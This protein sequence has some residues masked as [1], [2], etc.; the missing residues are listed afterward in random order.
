MNTVMRV[1][2]ASHLPLINREETAK[3]VKM[4]WSCSCDWSQ[5]DGILQSLI[6]RIITQTKSDVF[7]EGKLQ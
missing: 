3:N 5:K 6:R 2:A 7:Q 4:K 1:R